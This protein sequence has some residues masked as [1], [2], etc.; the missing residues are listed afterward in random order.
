MAKHWRA[1]SGPAGA[2][3][4][5]LVT[6]YHKSG[7]HVT[8][9]R[10]SMLARQMFYDSDGKLVTEWRKND[11]GKWSW[12]MKRNGVRTVYCI[13][14]TPEDEAT[15]GSFELSQSHGCLH[16]RPK[17]RDVMVDKRYL[18]RGTEVEVMPYNKRR[19]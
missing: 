19:G 12:N 14:T 13:H 9:S 4:A 7:K 2:V 11:F 16:I 17:D 3:T 1:A 6:W 15:T 18:V 10:A 8:V 5:S